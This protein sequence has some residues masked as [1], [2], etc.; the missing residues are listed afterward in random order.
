MQQ[1]AYSVEQFCETHDISRGTFY[2]LLK[3]GD[4]PR[5][6][7]VGRRTLISREAAADWRHAREVESS[8][9]GKN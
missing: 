6:F 3:E 2:Q 7:K 4:A 8:R 1:E 5:I 9:A